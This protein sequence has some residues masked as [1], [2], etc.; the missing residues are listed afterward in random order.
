M[1]PFPVE[2][3]LTDEWQLNN[4]MEY[5]EYRHTSK[6]YSM[7]LEGFKF[8]LIN[9]LTGN[10]VYVNKETQFETLNAMSIAAR[11]PQQ[12]LDREIEL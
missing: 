7:T 4:N 5:P 1:K 11:I 12:V 10:M 2:A 6:P 3:V 9:F 8:I